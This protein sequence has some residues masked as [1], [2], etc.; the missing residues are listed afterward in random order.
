MTCLFELKLIVTYHCDP[1]SALHE[2]ILQMNQKI[3]VF[4]MS[5]QFCDFGTN[6]YC[7]ISLPS[8]QFIFT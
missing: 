6:A 5:N 2:S 1:V 8:V 4:E 7:I 3:A